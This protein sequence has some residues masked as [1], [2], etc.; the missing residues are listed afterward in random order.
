[1]RKQLLIA[2]T[3][4]LASC[5]NETESLQ[6]Q[7]DVLQSEIK[8]TKEKISEEKTKNI[9]N[10]NT[11]TSLNKELNISNGTSSTI[12]NEA[13]AEN[14]N[15]YSQAMADAFGEYS[16]IDKNVASLKSDPAVK[17]QLQNIQNKI[18]DSTESFNTKLDGKSIP[19]SYK[20]IHNQV[21][22]ANA[23]FVS[24]MDK[25]VKA[26]TDSDQKLFNQGSAELNEGIN[27]I[28]SIQ[29]Q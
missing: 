25:V 14:F 28:D 1:M 13:Y 10:N 21:I 27:R 7:K 4:L 5:S 26:Y 3:L 11:L 15:I 12:S 22:A 2:S 20:D 18:N 19:I 23:E 9:S 29:F 8:A 16:S 6:K 24:G 17:V